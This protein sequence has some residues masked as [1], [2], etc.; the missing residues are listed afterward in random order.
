MGKELR[1]YMDDDTDVK[2]EDRTGRNEPHKLTGEEFYKYKW[3]A[4][5]ANATRQSLDFLQQQMREAERTLGSQVHQV[6]LHV[7]GLAAT[8]S[9]DVN[10]CIISED[11][12]ILPKPQVPQVPPVAQRR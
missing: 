4:T 2:T 10:Q 8:Y 11:G 7:Q 3:L 9:M 5:E 6:S 12:Y 1:D